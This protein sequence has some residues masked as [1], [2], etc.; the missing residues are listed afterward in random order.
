MPV[1]SFT[2]SRSRR[3]AATSCLY[4]TTLE[5]DAPIMALA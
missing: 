1:R 2:R 3:N 5:G 4:R